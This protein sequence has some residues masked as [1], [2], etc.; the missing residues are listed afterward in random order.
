[1]KNGKSY[2]LAHSVPKTTGNA[3]PV[4]NFV[5]DAYRSPPKE[6]HASHDQQAQLL[7]ATGMDFFLRDSVEISQAVRKIIFQ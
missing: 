6:F 3:E 1:M 2:L 4:R 7:T 5:F